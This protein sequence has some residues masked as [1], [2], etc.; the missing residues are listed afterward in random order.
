M[1]WMMDLNI[2]ENE[3][4]GSSGYYFVKIVIWNY[5]HIGNGKPFFVWKTL[6]LL[7]NPLQPLENPKAA[8]KTLKTLENS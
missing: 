1:L 3:L 8:E 5:I 4:R 7:K 2:L 6:T